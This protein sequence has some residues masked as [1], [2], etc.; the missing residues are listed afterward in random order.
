MK[1]KINRIYI[2]GGT[3]NGKTTLAKKIS[4]ITKIPFYTTDEFVY[5]KDWI[6]KYSDKQR[7]SMLKKAANK[8]RWIIEGVHR[9]DWIFP[10]FKKADFIIILKINP[11]IATKRVILRFIKRKIRKAEDKVGPLTDLP[12]IMKY[13][14]GY[15][16]DYYPKHIELAKKFNKDG[17]ILKNKKQIDNF[18][19]NLK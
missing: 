3:A 13:A 5:K 4:E 10:A 9:G 6:H 15:T 17:I 16:S 2:F 7:D 1:K 18:L 19:N 14:Y 8:K 11:V 12:R